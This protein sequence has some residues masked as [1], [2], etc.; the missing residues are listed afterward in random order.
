MSGSL[1]TRD[2]SAYDSPRMTEQQQE[3]NQISCLDEDQGEQLVL[4]SPEE[5]RTPKEMALWAGVIVLAALTVYS[6]A[7]RG[8]FLW[9]DDRHVSE[10]RN[11]RDFA[12]LVNDLDEVR[13]HP[14]AGRSSTTR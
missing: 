7:L 10:N 11:L 8:N 12:G 6:P 5:A 13:R 9:D 14:R 1:V 4:T 2:V 3:Q